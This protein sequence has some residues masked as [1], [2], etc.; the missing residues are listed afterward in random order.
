MTRV[1]IA[2]PASMLLALGAGACGSAT[3]G[4]N[5]SPAGETDV[6]GT[7]VS[8]PSGAGTAISSYGRAPSAPE[9]D[10]IVTLVKRYYAAAAAENGA[11][12][13]SL[14]YYIEVETLPEQYGGPPGPRW[15]HGA[16]TC[17]ALLTR[18]FEHFH[19]E[20]TG[21]V[22]ALAV[23]VK[24]GRGKELV[25]FPGLRLP[26]GVVKVRRE[27]D[28]WKVDGLLAVAPE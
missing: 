6:R 28:A 11:L 15:L 8:D 5:A 14:T 23:R 17:P 3:Q 2:L 24:D 18:V 22:D 1:A 16:S 9:A 7:T 26:E 13:C 19:S 27:G 21:S 10:A 20:L 25:D 12:A 4:H